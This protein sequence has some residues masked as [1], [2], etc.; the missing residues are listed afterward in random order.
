MRIGFSLLLAFAIAG[1]VWPEQRPTSAAI[2]LNSFYS[3]SP[4]GILQGRNS[5]SGHVFGDSRRPL[6]DVHVELLNELGVTISRM[7]TNGSGRYVFFGLPDGRYKVRVLPYGADYQEQTE[8]VTL[9]PVS[10]IP[11]SGAEIAQLDFYLRPRENANVGPLAA[12]GTIFVQE[13]PDPAKKLYEMGIADL[14]A[15]KEQEGFKSLKMALEIFPNYFAA[16]DRLGTEYAVRGNQ[17]GRYF[18]AARVL[19]TKAVEVNRKSFSSTFGLGFSQYHLGLI[20]QAIENLQRATNI[21]GKM[22]NGH[23]WLGIALKRAGKLAEAEAALKRADEMSKGKESEVHWHLAG[24][25]SDQKRYREAADELE[26][27]LNT[28]PDARDAEKIRQVIAQLR[29]KAP[30]P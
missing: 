22:I 13:V 23:M 16:L 9:L 6:A 28:K 26:K 3:A 12:P 17:D 30:S 27:F 11:G 25:Y 2:S 5:V 15:K 24:V 21:Q 18:E 8:D 4:L 20:D 7:R 19:L 14:K 10:A 1:A 29:K